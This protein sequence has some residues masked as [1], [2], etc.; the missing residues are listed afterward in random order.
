MFSNFNFIPFIFCHLHFL[1]HSVIFTYSCYFT[2]IF[3]FY[4]TNYIL[5]F[6]YFLPTTGNLG[7]YQERAKARELTDNDIK[8][9]LS[10]ELPQGQAILGGILG[11]GGKGGNGIS[12]NNKSKKTDDIDKG[13]PKVRRKEIYFYFH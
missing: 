10:L 5:Y 3:T 9:L 13:I 7:T 12:V 1:L 8:V 2:F 6:C 11:D 4:F